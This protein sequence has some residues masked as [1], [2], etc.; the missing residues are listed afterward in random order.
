MF[1]KLTQKAIPLLRQSR[2]Y[3]PMMASVKGLARARKIIQGEDACATA[4]FIATHLFLP[5]QFQAW[6]P[7]SIWLALQEHNIDISVVNRDKLLAITTLIQTPAFY[8]DAKI[9]SS[10][11][12]AFN[13]SISTPEGIDEV[14][15]AQLSWAVLEA[16]LLMQSLN[17]DPEFDYEPKKYA[18]VSCYQDGLHL[19][20]EL[21]VFCQPE[22]DILNNNDVQ[23][24]ASKVQRKWQTL[25]IDNVE[26]LTNLELREDPVDIQIAKLVAIRLYIHERSGQYLEQLLALR[27]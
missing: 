10:T 4:V 25:P 22:L 18:A 2:T 27:L 5:D 13:G 6:E 11:A 21:L 20:P 8:W 26:Q 17:V 1:A 16:E 12:M 23:S 7:E 24:A 9:F 3:E 15:P 19:A 14:S